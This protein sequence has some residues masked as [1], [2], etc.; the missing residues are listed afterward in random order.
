MTENESR[1]A[2][3]KAYMSAASDYVEWSAMRVE[4]EGAVRTAIAQLDADPLD[5][6]P[7]IETGASFST[8][9]PPE[10]S[11][12]QLGRVKLVRKR[13]YRVNMT[14][15]AIVALAEGP[16]REFTAK[17]A[18]PIIEQ[19]VGSDVAVTSVTSRLSD[20]MRE[21]LVEDT[22]RYVNRS[23][24]YAMTEAGYRRGHELSAS[25]HAALIPDES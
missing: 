14:Q 20:L 6:L 23:R 13:H 21:G 17:S 10:P 19:L 5:M 24:V 22:G 9:P 12:E 25:V 18:A 2:A 7:K 11:A 16:L 1:S 8:A 15:L 4:I 3:V